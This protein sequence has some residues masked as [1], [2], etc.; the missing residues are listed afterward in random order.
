MSLQQLK[1][2]FTRYNKKREDWALVRKAYQFALK[3]HEGQKRVS[4]DSFITHPLGVAS[5]L[6]ELELDLVTIMTGLLHDVLEDTPV[7]YEE[8]DDE[9]GEEVAAL[10]DG[11]TKLSRME[12]RSKEEHQAETWRK[13][14]VAMA[15][16]IRVILVKLADRTHNMRTLRYLNNSK[17]K[18]IAR[19]TLEI[20]A[21]LAHRLGIYKIKWELEDLAFR[22]LN[23]DDYYYL[24]D[25]LAKKRKERE[26]F[27]NQ[28]IEILRKKLDEAGLKADISGR[29]KHIYSIYHKMKEQGKDFSEIYDLTAVR[30]IVETIRDC[31]A[32]LGVVHTLWRPI[33]GQFND[34]I[35]MPKPN[36]YQSLHTT[37]V[38]AENELLEVQIRTKEMHR[39]AE[40]GIAAHWKY[41]EKVKDDKEFE[42]KLSWLRQLLEWQQDLKD[43][44][45]FMEHL[46]ID[47][48]SD[49]VFV[50]TPRG[51]VIDLPK[52][53]VPL[54]FAYRIHTD[55]GN[56]CVGAK[57]NGRIVPLDYQLKTGD[58]LEIITSKQGTPS[59]DWLKIVKSSQAKSK[60]RGWFKRERR[61]ENISKGKEILERDIRKLQLEPHLLLKDQLLEDVGRK[62]NLL[63]AD[64]V[65]AAVGYGGVSSKQLI[66]KLRDEYK[67]KFGEEKNLPPVEIKPW[68][69][70]SRPLRG[71]RIQG[72]DNLLVRFSKCCNP[73]PG[74]EITGF[75]TRGR[76][77]SIHR[78][79]CPN[80]ALLK[81]LKERF[82]DVRWEATDDLSFPVEI[83][84]IAM[85]R[86]GFLA[87]V[88][89]A[90]SESKI[91]I[92]A[93]NGR[94]TRDKMVVVN[95]TFVVKN[96]EQ[97]EHI[98]NKVRRLKDVYSVRRR[99][100]SSS[101]V[102]KK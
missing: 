21:P 48:F 88:M 62:Y 8:L 6:A 17:Q 50:F 43:A 38:C 94:T 70:A 32:S 52:G 30:I 96:L 79:D 45:E 64:D 3:A 39:T 56:H 9:F 40:Y 49:E 27:I 36:M 78:I 93:V 25:K 99:S 31:Y 54:D 11:V 35:A 85:E 53:S 16:D 47:L 75:V 91:N 15:R 2:R 51:D 10:V 92:T 74:D 76:G 26:E 59:R 1:R 84:I 60:I 7:T 46:K 33:P 95:L 12:F 44:H 69:E 58:I 13:M 55:I 37:V 41:K 29:P 80:V 77:V 73:L 42:E 97:L 57:V 102:R 18:E 100:G 28:V 81:S 98:M 19:E 5:I 68:K 20:Y 23:A 24:V 14:F 65:Y 61:E 86:P 101:A 67:K 89:Y 72:I 90:V 63:S 83:E 22:Y 34:Y 82:L 71:V 66:T 87:E 4:G